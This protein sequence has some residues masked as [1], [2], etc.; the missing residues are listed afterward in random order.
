M[1]IPMKLIL[2][3]GRYFEGPRWHAGRLWFV[4]CME[5]T[6]KPRPI[7]RARTAREVRGRYAM[8]PRYLAGWQDRRVDDVP[9]ASD[10]FR[11][12]PAFALRRSVTDSDRYDRRHDRRWTGARLCWRSR[13]RF[14]AAA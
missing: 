3:A 10:G 6:L 4:D 11:G 9:Q 2:D 14:A 13:L 1:M 5:R 12:R 8:W 7:R